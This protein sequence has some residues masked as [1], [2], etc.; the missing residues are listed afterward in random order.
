MSDKTTVDLI[1]VNLINILQWVSID[2][3][4]FSK[5]TPF[6]AEVKAL[7]EKYEVPSPFAR[8]AVTIPPPPV[9]EGKTRNA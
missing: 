3:T 1:K 4:E 6:Q 2:E 9:P 7:A 8:P 5:L